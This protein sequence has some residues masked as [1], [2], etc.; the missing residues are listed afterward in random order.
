MFLD[1]VT[2]NGYMTVLLINYGMGEYRLAPEFQAYSVTPLAWSQK[3]PEQQRQHVQKVLKVPLC[4]SSNQIQPTTRLSISVAECG[5]SS[6]APGFLNQIWHESEII[7]SH[8]K[9]I[10]LGGGSYCVTE[11]GKSVNVTIK[12]GSPT[13]RCRNSQS[14]AGLC[15]HILAMVDMIGTLPA[16]LDGFNKKKGKY[17]VLT[18]QKGRAKRP[19]R[20]KNKR[21]RIM[22]NSLQ[23]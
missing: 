12:G 15:F 5:V 9:V 6:V 11:Y 16:F 1:H 21:G 2:A 13:C 18:F 20:R 10:D 4:S 7:L 23:S 3:T 17:S 8:H 14:T 19:R 22:W